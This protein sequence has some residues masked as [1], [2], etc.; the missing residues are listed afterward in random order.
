MEA[1]AEIEGNVNRVSSSVG[2][3]QNLRAFLNKSRMTPKEKNEKTKRNILLALGEYGKTVLARWKT[4]DPKNR[5]DWMLQNGLILGLIDQGLSQIQ[6]R[7]FLGCGG[8][9]VERVRH[10]ERAER[11]P[12][13]HAFPEATITYLKVIVSQWKTEDGFPCAHR[14]PRQYLLQDNGKEATW[15][16]LHK[17][18]KKDW[19]NLLEE[20]KVE[21]RLMA[22]STFLQYVRFYF[23]GQFSFI[24]K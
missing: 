9:R 23:P 1:P 14:K 21:T 8:S 16:A 7:M 6:I 19:E 24:L 17:Q 18:Y 20:I 4:Y 5:D 3:S 2:G 12:P 11:K 10:H 22:Y 15:L 13:S